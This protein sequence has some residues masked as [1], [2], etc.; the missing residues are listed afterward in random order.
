MDTLSFARAVL[1]DVSFSS[2]KAFFW[3]PK[4]NLITYQSQSLGTLEGS[5]ALIHEVAHAVLGHQHYQSDIELLLLEVEAW[6][7]TADLAKQHGLELD[8][9][10]VQDCLDTYRDWLHQRASCPRCG[11]VSLQTS[12]TTYECF[13]CYNQWRV[14]T[15]RF[16]RPYRQS[17]TT[18]T[19]K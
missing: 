9:D 17:K 19:R 15:S 1:P 10:H 8:D 18:K 14:S 5:F 13:N 6:Q 4:Q 2:G 11:V 16:C 12:P 7:I 3:S